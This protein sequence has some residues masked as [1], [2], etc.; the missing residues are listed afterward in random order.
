[1]KKYVPG[2]GACVLAIMLS[3]FMAKKHAA[4]IQNSGT[5]TNYYYKYNGTNDFSASGYMNS[6]NWDARGFNPGSDN[7]P[8]G[9]DEQPCVI[10]APTNGQS[11]TQLINFFNDIGYSNVESYVENPSHVYYYQP[12]P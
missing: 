5:L 1:M 10:L 8:A 6:G 12:E 4:P 3:A 2:V 7:C 11:V 9:A